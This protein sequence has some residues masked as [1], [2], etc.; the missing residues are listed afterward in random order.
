MRIYNALFATLT[1]SLIAT[2]FALTAQ[3]F[4]APAPAQATTDALA[5]E[6]ALSPCPERAV[7]REG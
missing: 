1:L 6:A 2:L 4:L 3:T 7:A 5:F